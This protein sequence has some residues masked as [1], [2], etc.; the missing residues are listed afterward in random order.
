MS[1][2]SFSIPLTSASPLPFLPLSTHPVLSQSG[3]FSLKHFFTR[4]CFSDLFFNFFFCLPLSPFSYFPLIT[5]KLKYYL[6]RAF[7]TTQTYLADITQ[8]FLISI[9]FNFPSSFFFFISLPMDRMHFLGAQRERFLWILFTIVLTP[10]EDWDH[11]KH[12]IN[13]WQT[14]ELMKW[15]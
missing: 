12:S 6:T 2:Y 9:S 5:Y 7:L 10:R 14:N 3:E 15:K 8:T 11:H 4:S 1:V 13:T